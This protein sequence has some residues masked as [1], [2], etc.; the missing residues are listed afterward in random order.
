MI[1]EQAVNCL[2]AF[3]LLVNIFRT[4]RLIGYGK[5]SMACVF[6]LFAMIS[7]LISN[8][9]WIIYDILRPETRMPMAANE[10]GEAALFLLMASM[11]GD[12]IPKDGR[13]FRRER[14]GAVLFG[15]ASIILWIAWSGEWFQDIFFGSLFCVFLQVVARTVRQTGACSA[16]EWRAAEI[17]AVVLIA[18]EAAVLFLKDPL[19]T[20]LDVFCYIFMF[21]ILGYLLKKLIA[22][23]RRGK[24]AKRNLALAAGGFTW[25]T[26]IMYMSEG[27]WYIA[28]HLISVFLLVFL[29]VF[30]EKEVGR[31]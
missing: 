1:A 16:K 18:G 8:V 5:R 22:A 21:C 7:F 25:A 9:Y 11:L 29:Q 31:A 28:A 2:E 23:L 6:W 20:V 14:V 27:I 15:A 19:H 3:V 30:L 24:D 26:S 4:I 17:C 10:F 12:L 13:L